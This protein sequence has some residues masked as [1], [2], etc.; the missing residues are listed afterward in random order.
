MFA[1]LQLLAS[2]Q[3]NRPDSNSSKNP[4]IDIPS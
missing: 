4:Q 3:F 2:E 1:M